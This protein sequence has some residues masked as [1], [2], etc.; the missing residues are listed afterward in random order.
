MSN[1]ILE[2]AARA[3]RAWLPSLTLFL[4][5]TALISQTPFQVTYPDQKWIFGYISDEPPYE[6]MIV[7]FS[8]DPPTTYAQAIPFD[9][10]RNY[11]SY[12]DAFGT[13]RCYTNG[14]AIANQDHDIMENGEEANVEPSWYQYLAPQSAMALPVPDNEDHVLFVFKPVAYVDTPLIVELFGGTYEKSFACKKMQTALVDIAANQWSGEVLSKNELVLEDTLNICRATACRHGNGRDWW[15]LDFEFQGTDYYQMLL[16]PAGLH[17]RDTITTDSVFY[18]A[19]GFGIFSPDGTKYIM[20]YSVSWS[21]IMVDVFDFDRCEGV[22]FNQRRFFTDSSAV[23]TPNILVSPDSRYLYVANNVEIFQYD[24]SADDIKATQQLVA[25]WDGSA[26]PTPPFYTVFGMGQLTA[27]NRIYFCSHNS[28]SSLHV[29]NHPNRP[30]EACEVIQQGFDLPTFNASTIGWSP[31]FRLGPLDGSPCDTLG[32]DNSPIAKF[33]H[34]IIDT[35]A[36]QVWFEDH[37]LLASDTYTWDFGDGSPANYQKDPQHTYANAGAYEACLTVAN[38][39]GSDTYCDTVVVGQV[40]T[41]NI[42]KEAVQ[43]WPNPCTDAFN[44]TLPNTV[45]NATLTLY[46][47]LGNVVIQQPVFGFFIN[48][49]NVGQLAAGTY[50]YEIK[51]LDTLLQSGK[52]VKL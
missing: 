27:D 45:Q 50:L 30:G 1:F 22:L 23:F 26:D 12:C 5:T 9:F 2:R 28:M 41:Q 33:K 39:N 52:V 20:G 14:E 17:V 10:E 18:G 36:L 49:I 32:I 31:Y 8:T 37:S 34:D 25:T 7:D 38:E 6:G 47:V 4:C 48:K 46:D 43:V 11:A 42:Q 51:T 13:L 44:I 15:Y 24:L 29:I 40:A 16:D 3:L 21:S 19:D 35:A